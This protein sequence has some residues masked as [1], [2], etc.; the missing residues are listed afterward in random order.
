[1][2]HAWTHNKKTDNTHNNII[3]RTRLIILCRYLFKSRGTECKPVFFPPSVFRVSVSLSRR[4]GSAR[5]YRK[6][7]FV[8]DLAL[9]VLL[10]PSPL[11]FRRSPLF[12]PSLACHATP[13]PSY[14]NR[15]PLTDSALISCAGSSTSPEPMDRGKPWAVIP[16]V[17]SY[18]S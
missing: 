12:E 9:S 8:V 17:P 4:L 5:L 11:S 7:S 2:V 16:R 15:P 3:Y 1:M 13:E 18:L 14:L 6:S 10:S